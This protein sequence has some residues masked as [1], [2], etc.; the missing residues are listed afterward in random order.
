MVE[1]EKRA[2]S[3]RA[4]LFGLMFIFALGIVAMIIIP[5]VD[6]FVKPAMISASSL[7][8]ADLILYTKQVNF[9]MFAI[10]TTPFILSLVVMIY[11]VLS[12]VRRDRDEEL[13]V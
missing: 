8:G 4:W 6:D 1:L 5:V 2:D 13:I 9:V 10:K 12:V 3:G 11:L 7:Q